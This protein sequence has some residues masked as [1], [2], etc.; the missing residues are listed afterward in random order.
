LGLGKDVLDKHRVH[1]AQID[2]AVH[3][4]IA[5]V[6][7]SVS[8]GWDIRSFC[9]VHFHNQHVFPKFQGR[10]EI[11]SKRSIAP[12]VAAQQPAVKIDFA[13]GH[14]SVKVREYPFPYPCLPIG[15]TSPVAGNKLVVLFVEVVVGNLLIGVG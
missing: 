3:A 1:D 10:G 4:P 11:H 14:N 8:K 9:G 13:I 15:K 7:N 6:V 2:I 5:E 12:L